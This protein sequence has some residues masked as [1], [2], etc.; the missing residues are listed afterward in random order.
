MY[1]LLRLR[2]QAMLSILP[3]NCPGSRAFSSGLHCS[4]LTL[5]YATKQTARKTTGGR[6]GPYTLAGDRVEDEDEEL[7]DTGEDEEEEDEVL[8]QTLRSSCRTNA[9]NSTLQ[10]TCSITRS[11][12]VY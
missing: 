7:D 8:K 11:E 4:G 12:C 9:I 1:A 5:M 10:S 3:A 2:W 6:V